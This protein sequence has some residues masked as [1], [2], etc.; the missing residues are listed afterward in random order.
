M[1]LFYISHVDPTLWQ[2]ITL[3]IREALK[4]SW[5]NYTWVLNITTCRKCPYLVIV[6]KFAVLHAI[7]LVTGDRKIVIFTQALYLTN[8]D[9]SLFLAIGLVWLVCTDQILF[10]AARKSTKISGI[11]YVCICAYLFYLV[12]TY[13]ALV[14]TVYPSE[15]NSSVA[16][17][18]PWVTLQRMDGGNYLS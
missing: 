5:D 12:D 9:V 17:F 10:A 11:R 7:F 14:G 8:M 16:F 3:Y 1:D 13:W 4:D 6:H 2:K 18:F 15:S